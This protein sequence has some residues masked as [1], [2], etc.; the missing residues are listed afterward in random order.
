MTKAHAACRESRTGHAAGS[1]IDQEVRPLR[2]S[3]LL[4]AGDFEIRARA[5]CRPCGKT[6]ELSPDQL[7]G[8]ADMDAFKELERRFRCTDCGDRA[9]TVEPI[10]H[11]DWR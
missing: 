2:S 3:S 5:H 1:K 4:V 6:R 11:P 7:C 10:F 8:A 9:V